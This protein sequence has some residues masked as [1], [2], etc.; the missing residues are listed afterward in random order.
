MAKDNSKKVSKMAIDEKDLKSKTI[1]NPVCIGGIEQIGIKRISP[2]EI[3][4]YL[5]MHPA[6]PRG[7]EIKANRMINLIDEDLEGNIYENKSGH[8]YVK[9]AREYCKGIL[10]ESGGPIY[11]KQMSMGANRFGTS[12]SVLQTNVA[13]TEVLKFEYQHEIFFGAARYPK[14]LKGAGVNWGDIPMSDRIHLAGKMKI[15]PKT[16][17]IAKYTQLTKKYPERYES[18]YRYQGGYVNTR[19]HPDMKESSVEL[20]PIGPEID[21]SQVIQLAFDTLGDEPLGIPLVQFL[22]LTIKYLLNM[23]QA[24]AQTMVNFGFNKWKAT[25]P[26][27]DEKK[28]RAFGKTLA[29]IQKDSVVILPEGIT[30]DNIEPGTTEFDKIHP[31]YMKLIAIRLGIPMPLLTQSGTETNKASIVSMRADM[32]EDFFADELVIERCINEGF[33]KACQIKWPDLSIKELNSIVPKFKF[34]QPPEDQ[35]REM[36]RNLKF[37]LMIRN[38]ST[39]AKDWV[40]TGGQEDVIKMIGEKISELINKSMDK[41][42]KLS[43][44]MIPIEDKTENGKHTT[45]KGE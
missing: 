19:T 45:E 12:F 6:L 42:I 40:E 2:L 34:K 31:I 13:E 21:E 16:K 7:I 37:S 15:N 25:T 30:L 10:Y 17:K 20:V 14:S 3:P 9:E 26:F 8:K 28:M 23:E 4:K 35:D 1:P 36:D 11:V 39:A 32:Y 44:K 41:Q 29:N 38:F 27:K 22:H 33:F 24:G 43:N 5:L 18:N